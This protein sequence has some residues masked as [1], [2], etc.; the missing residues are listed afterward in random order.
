MLMDVE[1][2]FGIH[3]ECVST[4]VFGLKFSDNGSCLCKTCS[5]FLDATEYN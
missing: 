3:L 2:M 4:R 5:F 1:R